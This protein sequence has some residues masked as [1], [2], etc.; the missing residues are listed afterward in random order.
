M[1]VKIRKFQ[2]KDYYKLNLLYEEVRKQTFYWL[3]DSHFKSSLEDD[4][5]EETIFVATVNEKIVGFISI[6]EKDKFIHHLYIDNDYQ[7]RGIGKVLL[8]NIISNFKTISLKCLTKNIKA[9]KFYKKY[10]FQEKNFGISDDG[11]YILFKY[12]L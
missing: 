12:S 5:K 6:Y 7:D 4:T 3:D 1:E 10:G 8:D 2:N 11:E 9:V